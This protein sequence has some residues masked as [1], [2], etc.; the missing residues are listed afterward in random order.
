MSVNNASPEIEE[1]IRKKIIAVLL[2]SAKKPISSKINFQ[3]ELFLVTQSFPKFGSLFNFMP[4]RFG[5]YSNSAEFTIDNYP[6]IFDSNKQGV[7]LTSEGESYCKSALE[8]MQPENRKS[9]EK[10]II[11]IRSLY[12]NLSDQEFM[13]LI[14][15][16]YGYTEKS[17]I[18]EKL[19]QKKERLATGLLNKGIIT[20]QRYNE[21][22]SEE[23][24]VTA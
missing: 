2:G 1:E 22:I 6:E 8:Q 16:T 13:F 18:F 10:V 20:H 15:K 23:N 21:L 4:H 19:M 24:E 9:L 5:P 12:D 14:Y 17:D 7:L 3:K 11:N